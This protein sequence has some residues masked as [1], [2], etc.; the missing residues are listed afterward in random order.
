MMIV[1]LHIIQI[2]FKPSPDPAKFL[3]NFVGSTFSI[4]TAR[5]SGML[6]DQTPPS[7]ARCTLVP[8]VKGALVYEIRDQALL[9]YIIFL[10]FTLNYIFLAVFIDNYYQSLRKNEW[11]T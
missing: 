1:F 8:L 4:L 5:C 10:S 6:A 11:A 2:S 9:T 7:Q 3:K